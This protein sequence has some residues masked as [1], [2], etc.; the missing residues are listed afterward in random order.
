MKRCQG[1]YLEERCMKN[2]H[3]AHC[4]TRILFLLNSK[5]HKRNELWQY[6]LTF[7]KHEYKSSELI[8]NLT[9]KYV[10]YPLSKQKR[11]RQRRSI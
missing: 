9:V 10:K 2:V 8:R 11:H 1:M 5:A 6:L 7:H 4:E 3:T